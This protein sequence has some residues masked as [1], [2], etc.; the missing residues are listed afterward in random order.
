MLQECGLQARGFDGRSQNVAEARARFPE[1]PFEQGDVENLAICDGGLYDFVLCFGLLYHLENPL[2]AMRNLRAMTGK[3]LLLESMCVPGEKTAALLRE[4]PRLDNQSLTEVAFYPSEATL[5]KMLYRTGFHVVYRIVNLPEHDDFRET[6]TH[7]RRRTMLLASHFP[8]D[9]AGLRLCPET[10]DA[11]DPWSKGLPQPGGPVA[12][13]RRF[14]GLSG[15]EKYFAAAQ[16]M[17]RIFPFLRVPLR[18]P[19]GAWWLAESSALD[20]ELAHEGYET[21]E[22]SFVQRLLRPGAPWTVFAAGVEVRGPQRPGDRLRA[23]AAR[24]AAAA[25]ARETESRSERHRA[26]VRLGPGRGRGRTVSGREWPGWLQ[27]PAAPR[28]AGAGHHSEGD[29][30]PRG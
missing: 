13:A 1:I 7:A 23:F 3:C 2:L 14:L 11:H 15:R 28:G 26:A 22:L 29:A 27:Q 17:R 9:F 6:T 20:Y 4:E 16:H 19:F 21:A 12:R 8:V 24:T 25:A 30:A 18:L 10:H 5:I